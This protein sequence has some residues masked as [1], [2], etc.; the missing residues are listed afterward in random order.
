MLSLI[1]AGWNELLIAAFPDN[2]TELN[3][4]YLE[5]KKNDNKPP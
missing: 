2:H 5:K 3:A 4:L 1:R